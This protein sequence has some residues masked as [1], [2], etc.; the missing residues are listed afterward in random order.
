MYCPDRMACGVLEKAKSDNHT[1]TALDLSPLEGTCIEVGDIE[2]IIV[3]DLVR[4]VF[5]AGPPRFLETLASPLRYLNS[6]FWPSLVA[7]HPHNACRSGISLFTSITE[8][9][10]I[11]ASGKVFVSACLEMLL[12]SIGLSWK[13]GKKGTFPLGALVRGGCTFAA[14][15]TAGVLGYCQSALSHRIVLSRWQVENGGTRFA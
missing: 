12:A 10:D 5:L 9:G 2:R 11:P 1:C 8:C 6:R 4:L 15:G 14:S 7:N 13:L 3:H